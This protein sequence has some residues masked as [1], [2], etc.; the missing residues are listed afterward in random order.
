[1]RK[2]VGRY[3]QNCH[4]C[5]RS[6]ATHHAP[7]G[8]LRPLSVP[9]RPWQDISIDF[10]TGLPISSTYDA[11]LVVVDTLSRIR[12]FIPCNRTV[13]AQAVAN[14]YLDTIWRLHGLQETIT[15]DQ[16][17]QFIAKFWQAHGQ[18]LQIEPRISSSFHP[19]TDGLTEK[20]NAVMEQYLR[21]YLN[22]QQSDWAQWLPIAE[23][24]ANNSISNTTTVTPF[25]A[26]YGFNP[27]F[28]T[29]TTPG[30]QDV[31]SLDSNGFTNKMNELHQLLQAEMKRAQFIDAEN[32]DNR[33]DPAPVYQIG[34]EVWLIAKNIRTKR[35]ARK[36]D[37]K[38]LGR[39]RIKKV[40]SP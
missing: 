40:I 17:T 1:M 24:S 14:M 9:Q 10:K 13:N 6:K 28:T 37:W 12:H 38:R 23:F 36:L 26:N 29:L 22:Y 15:S 7:H 27:R 39:F 31:S 3:A 35:P 8:V 33:R 21:S 34:D 20:V 18:P 30:D 19:Q 5:S 4:T 11:I 32:A 2:Y 25:F 16:G